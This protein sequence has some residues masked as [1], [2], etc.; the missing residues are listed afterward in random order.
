VLRAEAGFEA[1]QPSSN[2]KGIYDGR[3]MAQKMR[4]SS[5]WMK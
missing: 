4:T 2:L 1:I 3:A 5:L